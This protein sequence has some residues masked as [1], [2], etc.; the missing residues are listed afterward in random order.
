MT[1]Y[2]HALVTGIT[3]YTRGTRVCWCLEWRDQG[4]RRGSRGPR[5]SLIDGR[6]AGRGVSGGGG[7]G[8]DVVEPRRPG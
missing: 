2:Q 4:W 5:Q 1:S 8:L 6:P 7:G 3:W